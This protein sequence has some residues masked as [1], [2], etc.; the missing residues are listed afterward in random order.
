MTPELKELAQRLLD[1]AVEYNEMAN[2]EGI[3][4]AVIWLTGSDGELVIVTRGEYRERL[5]R[6]IQETGPTRSFGYAKETA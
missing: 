3:H 1:T 4:G 5:M 2:K 6:N